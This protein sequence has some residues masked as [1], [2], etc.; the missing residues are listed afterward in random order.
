MTEMPWP[1]R[2]QRTRRSN[3]VGLSRRSVQAAQHFWAP[4][5]SGKNKKPTPKTPPNLRRYDWKTRIILVMVLILPIP[6][7]YNIFAYIM[8]D[9]NGICM[10]INIPY[11]DAMGYESRTA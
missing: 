9:F 11:M 5:K 3:G 6:S 4:G 10:W 7:I 8:V 2:H 1:L